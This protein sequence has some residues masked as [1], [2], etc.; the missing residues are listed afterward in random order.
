MPDAENPVAQQFSPDETPVYKRVGDVELRMHVF[1]PAGWA[2]SDRRGGIVFFFGGGWVSGSPTQFYSHCRRLADLGMVAMAAEY[3][4]K[5]THG[6]TPCECV[7]DGKSAI[8]W[9]RS[10]AAALGIDPE[11][12]AAGGGSAGGHVAA[13]TAFSK[14]F[15]D[16]ADNLGVSCL[17]V[18]LALF[19]PVS[20]N[21]PGEFGHEAVADRWEDFSPAHNIAAPAPPAILFLGTEDKLIPVATAER[22]RDRIRACGAACELHL[23]DGEGHGFFNYGDGA[24]PSYPDTVAKMVAFLKACGML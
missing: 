2:A 16:P 18:A 7:A 19:N 14:G 15:D 1:K 12:V 17:P 23:Y 5:N 3:R 8:R 9:V 20:D 22:F 4:V 10:H 13:A 21:G 11:R 24:N 6:T